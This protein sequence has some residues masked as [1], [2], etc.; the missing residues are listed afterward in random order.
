M[1][2]LCFVLT[3]LLLTV[4]AF[5]D[6]TIT[7]EQVGD[8]NA[9]EISYAMDGG[10][11]NLPRAFGLDISTTAGTIDDIS[12]TDPCFWV[13]PG[14]IQITGGD[15]TSLG[16]PVAPDEDP[17]AQGQLGTS[18][19]TIEMGSLY[20]SSDPN[21]QTAPASSGVLL[22]I[23]VSDD[24][25]GIVVE[26]NGA[27][28]EV[29]LESTDP[30]PT[31]LPTSCE[32]EVITAAPCPGDITGSV[33]GFV[34]GPPPTFIDTFNSGLW[35]GPDGKVDVTDVQ[36]LILLL[37]WDGT[38]LVVSPVPSQA[39]AGDITGSVTG[40]V[41]GPPPTFIDT[42]NSSLWTGADGKIDNFDLQ[43]L[44]FLLQWDGTALVYTCP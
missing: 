16:N 25:N 10:D 24:C 17:G 22:T 14:T 12:T 27:R 8:T 13:Y 23:L 4:P 21:H 28:G 36:A 44:I 7:C 32:V 35:T 20:H 31:N 43:A 40:F 15:I 26:G 18:A 41:P 5:A 9:V 29:V 42:F 30:A 34:P 37:Q 1:R 33:T 3:A 6:M 19:I 2:N 11:A 38:A 39:S